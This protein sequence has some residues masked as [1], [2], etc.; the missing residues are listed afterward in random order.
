MISKKYL[1]KLLTEKGYGSAWT[2]TGPDDLPVQRDEYR[3]C[4]VDGEERYYYLSL[5]IYN[6]EKRLDQGLMSIPT[7]SDLLSM[8]QYTV[9]TDQGF[10]NRDYLEADKHTYKS[11]FWSVELEEVDE[12]GLAI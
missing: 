3:K 9:L 6:I 7:D 5:T 1:N 12:L 2:G 4:L 10:L 11:L 8:F